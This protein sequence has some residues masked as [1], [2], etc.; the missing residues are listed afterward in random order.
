MNRERAIEHVVI[1]A[2]VVT[3]GLILYARVT[4][5]RPPVIAAAPSVVAPPALSIPWLN[6]D[7]YA[8]PVPRDTGAD[9]A[10][11]DG[12][13][14]YRQRY[15]EPAPTGLS[16]TLQDIEKRAELMRLLEESQKTLLPRAKP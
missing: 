6:L 1:A 5:P 9:Y 15:S 8:A 11:N 3:G 2:V 7:Q 10:L 12:V 14:R 4:S 16:E 13:Y